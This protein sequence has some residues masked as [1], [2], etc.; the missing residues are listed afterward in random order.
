[1]DYEVLLP[2]GMISLSI[3]IWIMIL[4]MDIV[5]VGE[6]VEEVPWALNIRALIIGSSSRGIFNQGTPSIW[7]E[8]DPS[9]SLAD[10]TGGSSQANEKANRLALMYRRPFELMNPVT[11][12]EV[13]PFPNEKVL[14]SRPETKSVL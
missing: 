14:N 5:F 6:W 12:D 8:E 3:R 10:A 9:Q 4:I 13:H 11:L 7:N 2:L 1:M